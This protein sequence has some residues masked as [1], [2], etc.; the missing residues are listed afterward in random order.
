MD[1]I[2]AEVEQTYASSYDNYESHTRFHCYVTADTFEN[3]LKAARALITDTAFEGMD[4][5]ATDGWHL[6]TMCKLT[7]PGSGGTEHASCMIVDKSYIDE[8][9]LKT[10]EELQNEQKG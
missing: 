10:Y 2:Y 8:M 9:G 5:E 7:E 3:A 6:Y 1:T 4:W